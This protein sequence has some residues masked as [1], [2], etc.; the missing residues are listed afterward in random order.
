MNDTNPDSSPPTET[1]I[2]REASELLDRE[3]NAY[4]KSFDTIWSDRYSKQ[5]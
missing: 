4:K 1:S 2:F 5:E 3:S